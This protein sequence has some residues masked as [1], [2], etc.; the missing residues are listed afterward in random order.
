MKKKKARVVKKHEINRHVIENIKFT[1][2]DWLKEDTSGS[3]SQL[4]LSYFVCPP[5]PFEMS[6]NIYYFPKSMHT[7]NFCIAMQ[8]YLCT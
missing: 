4:P 2:I 5:F 7:S 6:H 8:N 3:F 1:R